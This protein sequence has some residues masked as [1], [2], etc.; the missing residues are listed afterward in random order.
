LGFVRYEHVIKGANAT[1]LFYCGACHSSWE[2]AA[3]EKAPT[4]SS[5]KLPKP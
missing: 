3:T 4:K 5:P 2:A 1:V